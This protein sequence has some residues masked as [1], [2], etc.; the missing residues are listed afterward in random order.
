MPADTDP[1]TLPRHLNQ[2]P[3][4]AFGL[5]PDPLALKFR[6]LNT[7][8]SFQLNHQARALQHDF[9]AVT[10]MARVNQK[11]CAYNHHLQPGKGQ[12]QV[13]TLQPEKTGNAQGH[14]AKGNVELEQLRRCHRAVAA[15]LPLQL[16]GIGL[17]GHAHGCKAKSEVGSRQ[18]K[19]KIS[20][21]LMQNASKQGDIPE[22]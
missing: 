17:T 20:R 4:A 8:R 9:F 11:S 18:K 12:D 5:H 1:V 19:L 13:R 14:N 3:V 7:T 22:D 6:A 21:A 16:R 15:Q 10:R 2:R